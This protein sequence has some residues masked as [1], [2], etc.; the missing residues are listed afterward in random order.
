[1][2]TK[3]LHCAPALAAGLGAALSGCTSSDMSIA[4]GPNGPVPPAE[5]GMASSYGAPQTVSNAF[6]PA[7][8]NASPVASSPVEK[9]ASAPLAPASEPQPATAATS[10][11]PVQ[12]AAA[13]SQPKAVWTVGPAPAGMSPPPAPQP[14]ETAA[15]ASREPSP[16]IAAVE[17]NEPQPEPQA[18][19][20]LAAATP[21]PAQAAP[22]ASPAVAQNTV[23]EVQFLPV[24]GA[25]E[26]NAE[27]LARA[28]SEEAQA[29]GLEIRPANG[30]VAPVRLKGYFSAF[31][32]S[33][34][35]KLVYVWDVIDPE[36]RRVRRIQGQETIAGT[37][38]DPWA[39]VDLDVLRRVAQETMREA[40]TLPAQS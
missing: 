10:P 25:P 37:D 22:P 1:M 15:V 9:V 3:I 4:M 14:A 19:P 32:D 31:P 27:W 6:E 26:Q 5:I 13:S 20:Q 33:G 18:E 38:A 34:A 24:V 36:N 28:L 2:A 8:V 7:P 21:S 11:Q 16:A 23:R 30:P 39:K 29:T 40:S 35:T 17:T 12:V